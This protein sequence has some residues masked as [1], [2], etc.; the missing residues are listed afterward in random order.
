M[1]FLNRLRDEAALAGVEIRTGRFQRTMALIT[2]FSAIV[3]GFEAFVQH[4]RGA[5]ADPLMWTPVALTPPTAA[6]AGAAL[7]SERAAR[8]VL[9]GLAAVTLADGLLGFGLHLRGIR[10]MP[11]G[12]TVGQYNVVMGPPVFAPLLMSVV[13]VTGILAALLRREQPNVAPWSRPPVAAAARMVA[14]RSG[15]RGALTRLAEAVATGEFEQ[16]MAAITAGFGA[17]AGGE[18]YFEHM[19]GS[20]NQRAMWTP[21]WVTPPMVAAAAGAVASE[22][23]ARRVLPVASAFTFVDGMLGFGLHLRGIRNMPGGFGNLRFNATL[24]PPMF[25]PLLFSA[26]GLTGFIASILRRR[27]Q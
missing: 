17:L 1:S 19:R 23:I 24:G 25:A 18:A 27:S 16:S 13:G 11:G 3:S 14:R 9:P 21:V 12:L 5:F 4:D 26:V 8:T 20:F 2:G 22:R 7:V 6:A 10:R 15:S